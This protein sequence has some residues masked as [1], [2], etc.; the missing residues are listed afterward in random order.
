[1]LTSGEVPFTI[2]AGETPTVILLQGSNGRLPFPQTYAS[3]FRKLIDAQVGRETEDAV[4]LH[5]SL[6]GLLFDPMDSAGD[7][8]QVVSIISEGDVSITT[9]APSAYVALNINMAEGA[10]TYDGQSELLIVGA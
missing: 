5:D 6:N 3:Y 2:A 7:L 1:S 10:V 8:A 4:K 9:G